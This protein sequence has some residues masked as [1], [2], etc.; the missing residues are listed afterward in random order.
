MIEVPALLWQLD[1]LVKV[2]DF[3]SVGTNDLLQ[4]MTASD[5]GNVLVAQRFDPLSRPF[6]RALKSIADTCGP[7][8]PVTLCGELAGNPLAAM[9]LV[10]LGFRSL[11]MSPASI[12]PVKAMI[13]AL[14]AKNVRDEV[15]SLLAGD[16][17]ETIRP[18][19][20]KFA[21]A[22]GVPH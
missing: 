21:K 1:G 15:V 11:S 7:R 3:V 4:F 10:A 22:A 13:L 20:I 9:A 8:M 5:R 14:N 19:L 12:G 16:T 18:A 17:G 2:A 6:L